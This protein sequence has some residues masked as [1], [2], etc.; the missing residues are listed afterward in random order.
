M[1]AGGWCRLDTRIDKQIL[2][3]DLGP[4]KERAAKREKASAQGAADDSHKDEAHKTIKYVMAS[5]LENS[6]KRQVSDLRWLPPDGNCP[7]TDAIRIL[8]AA[9]AV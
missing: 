8:L 4:A 7:F 9:P 3:Y 5:T 6:H 2:L 1:R